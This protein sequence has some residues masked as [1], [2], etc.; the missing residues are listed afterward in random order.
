[1]TV[2]NKPIVTYQSEPY[3]E[4]WGENI[5]VAYLDNVSGHPRNHLNGGSVRTSKIVNYDPETGRI[6]T[7]N[8]VYIKA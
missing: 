2:S 4:K 8:T 1:M 3:I 6:E 5:Y 7:L